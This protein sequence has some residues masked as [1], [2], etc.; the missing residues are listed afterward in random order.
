MSGLQKS[1]AK[2]ARRRCR[3]NRLAHVKVHANVLLGF[4][5]VSVLYRRKET[6]V[7]QGLNKN[8]IQTRIPGGLD[9]FDSDGSVGMNDEMGYRNRLVGLLAQLVWH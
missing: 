2:R 5:R 3:A 6:P 7:S 4:N 8:L 9:E 1:R